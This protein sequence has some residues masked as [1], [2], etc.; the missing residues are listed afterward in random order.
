MLRGR[1]IGGYT[2]GGGGPPIYIYIVNS[3]GSVFTGGLSVH[4]AIF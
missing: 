3:V 1:R 4:P 2:Q